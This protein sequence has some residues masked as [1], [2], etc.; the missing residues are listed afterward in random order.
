[1]LKTLS[2]LALAPLGLAL[3][4][5]AA[6][7]ST[8]SKNGADG[9]AAAPKGAALAESGESEESVALD[10]VP[11]DVR[12][13][14]AGAVAGIV[15]SKAERETENGAT[16]YTLCGTANGKCYEVEVSAAGKVLEVEDGDCDECEDGEEGE[17]R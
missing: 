9:A 6:A 17:D 7:S 13:A 12:S 10:S 1:M 15:F 5:C 4:A 2:L 8:D 3:C 11:A 16:V 14:A